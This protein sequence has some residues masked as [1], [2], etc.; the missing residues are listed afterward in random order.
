MKLRDYQTAIKN[1][2]YT[3]WQEGY[4][5]VLLVKPTGMGKTV[6]FCSITED[7]AVTHCQEVI[8]G[9]SNYPT[10][11]VVH[12]KELVQQ[13]CLTLSGMDISHNI[14]ATKNVIRGIIA[15]ERRFHNKAFYN[16]NANVT[17]IS[18]D[19]LNSRILKYEKWAKTVK[20]WITDEAAHLLKQNKWGRAVSYFENAV[21]L[22]V[23]ATPERL[24]RKGLGSHVD[25]VFDTLVEGPNTAWGIDNGFLSKYKIAIPSSDYKQFL[26]AAG[27][28]A[29]Y[30]KQAMA[31]ASKKSHIIGDVVKNYLKF[32]SNKQA[33][34][35]A[36]DI[37]TGE[38]METKFTDVGITCKFLSS[39]NTDQERLQNLIDYKD[40]KINVLINVDLFDEGLDVPG[41]ECVIM[42][43]PTMS[44]GKYL[45][46]IGRGLRIQSGKDYMVLIDHVGNV[47]QH[48]LP[49]QKRFWTL[50]RIVKR[51]SK[52]NLIRIC[53]NVECCAPFDRTLSE[54][55]YCG[56]KDMPSKGGAKNPRAA[57]EQV[58]GDL[59]LL[60]PAVLRKLEKD[61]VLDDPA[62]VGQRVTHAAGIPAG[63]RA[64]KNQLARI[65]TQKELRESVAK[66]AG[67]LRHQGFTDRQIHKY[68]YAHHDMTITEALSLKRVEMLKLMEEIE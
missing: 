23:T 56:F 33:I 9:I 63:L 35:F 54:C 50:D 16:H 61:I 42:A 3:A 48:G 10:A 27:D 6:T 38:K 53:K 67:R 13:I 4:K 2:V 18:V 11:I 29:D 22:G 65:E 31:E 34:V 36:T 19:T 49:C 40:K 62:I 45:Q 30:T 32:A 47:I 58:D 25:G 1:D 66:W 39:K 24:D 57:L 43:R 26:K 21:G 46:M 64:A 37:D 14:I 68:F 41:I 17:V 20:F 28:G 15:A 12:R 44:L 52:V 51:K 59:F 5:N 8:K 55:P 60:D 7:L